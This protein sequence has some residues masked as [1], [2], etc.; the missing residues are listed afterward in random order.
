MVNSN[1]F[2]QP[3]LNGAVLTNNTN[4]TNQIKEDDSETSSSS[5]SASVIENNYNL[6]CSNLKAKNSKVDAS[7]T[8]RAVVDLL[9]SLN[10]PSSKDASFQYLKTIQ[11]YPGGSNVLNNNSPIKKTAKTSPNGTPN[12]LPQ[13]TND[14]DV[15]ESPLS[16]LVPHNRIFAHVPG[17]LSLLSNVVKY[18]VIF[19]FIVK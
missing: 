4:N 19:D 8:T 12:R 6:I 5:G 3:L 14:T 15:C 17:R 9:V 2:Q 11:N 13:R 16:S 1:E 18:K 7:M 10:G